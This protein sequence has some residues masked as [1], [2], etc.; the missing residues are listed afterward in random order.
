MLLDALQNLLW[1]VEHQ[2]THHL[3][4]PS[5]DGILTPLRGDSIP[6]SFYLALNFPQSLIAIHEH[7]ILPSFFFASLAGVS[8]IAVLPYEWFYVLWLCVCFLFINNIM[9]VGTDDHLEMTLMM[10]ILS[11]RNIRT[12]LKAGTE[13]ITN[14]NRYFSSYSLL[15]CLASYSRLG[16]R[17]K[18]S[19]S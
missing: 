11:P 6:H 18:V 14:L 19:L 4:L 16:Y 3:Y 8:L 10:F 2:P 5:I 9:I 15:Y 7:I 12:R 1:F 17:A 13:P